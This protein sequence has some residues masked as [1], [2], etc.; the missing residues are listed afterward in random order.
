MSGSPDLCEELDNKNQE[1]KAKLEMIGFP[2]DCPI[3]E[4]CL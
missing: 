4:V 2:T 1:A 3:T